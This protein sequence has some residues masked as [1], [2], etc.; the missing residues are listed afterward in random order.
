MWI[1]ILLIIF[2]AAVVVFLNAEFSPAKSEFKN[3]VD[4]KEGTAPASGVF[5][6]EDIIALPL[7]VQRY[8]R[9]CG[10]LGTPKMQ[11]MKACLKNVDFFMSRNK[12][13]KIDY[14]QFNCAD[15]PERY[16]LI[17]S[18]IFGIPFEGLDSYYNGKGSMKGVIAKVIELFNQRGENMDRASLVTWLAESLMVPNAALQDFVE[19][20][21]VDETHAKAKI[22]W[23]GICA[24]G[25]FS[26]DRNGKLIE[27]RTGDRV[28]TDMNGKETKAEW[29]ALFLEY[30][31]VNGLLQPDIIQSVWH[32]NDGDCVYFNDNQSKIKIWY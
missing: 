3:I 12:V 6:E 9:Y 8:F 22:S 30:H 32:Y 2:A 20:E 18:R 17:S 21:P 31:L 26:F 4:E 10:Y 14:K 16:A 5:T 25:V 29:S 15:R 24:E 27:F 11:Y 1:A 23:E 19:W 28:A 13:I 7:P